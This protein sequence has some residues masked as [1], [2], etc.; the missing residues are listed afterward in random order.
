MDNL[1]ILV[2]VAIGAYLFGSIPSGIIASKARGIDLR[3]HGSGSSGA[4]NTLRVLGWKTAVA[5]VL[6]DAGKGALAVLVA[7]WLVGSTDAE[8]VACLAA[9]A[10]HNWPVYVGFRG[11]RGV[12]T[13]FGAILM[14]SPWAALF[15][16]AIFIVV[17][18]VSRYVSLGS[19]A[20][21]VMTFVSFSLLAYFG[22]LRWEYVA[23]AAIGVPVVIYQHRDNINR[24]LSGR[25][26]KLFE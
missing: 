3:Q 17:I 1:P 18:L 25:E 14:I 5:V 2:L 10:G 23:M 6:A 7:R 11:G 21:A 12:A 22:E 15:C 8:V 4:T 9:I 16:A 13:S 20:A 26:R 19:L 24:L